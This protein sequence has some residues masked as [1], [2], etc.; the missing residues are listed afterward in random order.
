MQGVY[1]SRPGLPAPHARKHTSPDRSWFKFSA[2]PGPCPKLTAYKVASRTVCFLRTY[3]ARIYFIG[4]N[5]SLAR[6]LVPHPSCPV[7]DN[8]ARSLCRAHVGLWLA[9]GSLACS[10]FALPGAGWGLASELGVCLMDILRMLT[11]LQCTVRVRHAIQFGHC[12]RKKSPYLFYSG[13]FPICQP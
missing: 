13:C 2:A 6:L 10:S 9:R 12:P 8:R 7:D 11:C 5:S 3:S 1:E 4:T